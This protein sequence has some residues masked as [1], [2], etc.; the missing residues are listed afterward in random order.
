MPRQRLSH[1]KTCASQL[2]FLSISRFFPSVYA[3]NQW[4]IESPITYTVGDVDVPV[5]NSQET[6]W[7]AP[8]NG[9]GV[10]A[11]LRGSTD[12][13]RFD[14]PGP[15]LFTGLTS[16]PSLALPLSFD[17]PAATWEYFDFST[18]SVLGY[19]SV[20]NA[21]FQVVSQ[22][23]PEPSFTILAGLSIAGLSGLKMAR[24]RTPFKAD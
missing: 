5:Q 13:I 11:I 3:A 18:G 9:G 7:L 2:S 14:F 19:G 21:Q 16:S 22:V 15:Q 8:S 1:P 20:L 24:P 6:F 4:D 10:S 23:A 17:A 12:G